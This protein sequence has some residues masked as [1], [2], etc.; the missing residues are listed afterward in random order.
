[1][2]RL[3]VRIG[4]LASVLLLAA[5]MVGATTAQAGPFFADGPVDASA[6]NPL[7]DCDPGPPGPGPGVNFPDSEVE[8]WVD[9]NPTNPLNIVGIYQQDRWSN[10]AA[11]SNVVTWSD[12]GGESWTQV[13]APVGTAC[14]GGP[15]DRATD[16][17]LSFSPNGTLHAMSLVTDADPLTTGGFGDNGMTYNR[18]TDGGRTWEPF[19]LLI[20]DTNPRFLNDKNS[21]TA[22]PNDSRFVYAVWD[23][24]QESGRQI[25]HPAHP[26]GLGFKG[27]IY[28]TRTTN[29]GSSWEP[30]RKIY[31]TGANK[32]T[33]GNQIVVEPAGEG[34]S[35][36]DFFGD[37]VNASERRQTLGPIGLSYIRSDDNG[38]TWTK[39]QKTADMLPMTLF[40]EDSVIDTEPV[41]CPDPSDTG[42][43]PIRAGDLLPEVAVN[44]TNGDL[45]AVWM[46]ARFGTGGVPFAAG[47]FQFDQI[48]FIQSTDGGAT[49]STPIKVNQTP[50]TEPRDD[51]QA[52][53][54]SVHV[55]D[56]GT[57]SVTYYDFRNNTPNTASLDTDHWAV[58]CHPASENC[59]NPANWTPGDETRLTPSSFNIREAAFARGYFLGDYVGLASA[60]SDFVP[61]FGS[62]VGAGPSNVFVNR[63]GP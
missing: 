24:V 27:P 10:G 55:A 61:L 11:K 45:Y 3:T 51:Q 54:P 7:E 15:F 18:S 37:I 17:W 44:R 63:F 60:S 39:P 28:F 56:D 49:W 53:T 2:R 8:P 41:P 1:M 36:F 20:E 9:V 22:D 33:I 4:L 46:D 16:P 42:A 5:A 43:C 21:I 62:T 26:I 50:A 52:F 14:T 6:T 38:A 19:Q 30:A 13:A 31:E 23:R 40:R 12:D 58:H 34:G 59:A 35:L 48:A 57:I 47:A 29:G 25:I 32:Q